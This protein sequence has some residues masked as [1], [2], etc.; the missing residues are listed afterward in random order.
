MELLPKS[1]RVAGAAASMAV[2]LLLFPVA[3]LYAAAPAQLYERHCAACHG[4]NGDGR[5]RA[6][7]G[8]DPPPRDF[9]TAQ[10]W[11]ELSRE[12][13]IVSVTHGRPGTAMAGWGSRLSEEQIAGV[14]DYVRS[15]FMQPPAV[16]ET[17]PG[18]RLYERHCAACH[19]DK[20]SGA[21][22]TE[23]SLDP[24]P[25]DFT[26]PAAREELSRERMITSVTHGRP[27]TAMMPFKS[28]LEAGE[29]ALVVDYIRS[30][31]MSGGGAGGEEP[32]SS[33]AT[34]H[35]A[36]PPAP[37]AVAADM[38]AAFPHG[39]AGDPDAGRR[40]YMDNCATC[41]GRRGDGDGPRAS[42]IDPPPRNFLASRARRTLNRPALFRAISA[43]KRGT[44]M[45]AWSTVLDEQQIANVAEFVF[46]SFIRPSGA[47]PETPVHKKKPMK[48]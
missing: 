3:A 8:L 4:E 36:P 21:T 15:T 32:S 16:G 24:S 40:F 25:R 39:L 28:R 17:D 45:P 11:R 19:G 34:A 22:W 35:P 9:T 31:F 5:S 47:A 12:R 41:H 27:G 33:A 42:S 18:E 2:V 14:V 7:F 48:N 20:G 46:T 30:N 23:H 38:S 13:M 37:E 29:I 44:V 10:A 1:F 43:G 6:Q 26:A